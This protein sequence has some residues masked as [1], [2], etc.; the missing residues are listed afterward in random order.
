MPADRIHDFP[1]AL[2]WSVDVGRPDEHLR[3]KA[4]STFANGPRIFRL[5]ER[6]LVI[7]NIIE[8]DEDVNGGHSAAA[9]RRFH[10]Q[11]IRLLRLVV[12][13]LRYEY[14]AHLRIGPKLVRAET[15]QCV[16]QFA[17]GTAVVILCINVTEASAGFRI[18]QDRQFVHRPRELGA[19]IVGI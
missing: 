10:R 4:G 9:V 11:G 15:T 8:F 2:H 17:E 6:R 3:I 14:P 7:V 5:L 16:R 18:F 1:I 12:Q 13:F 19:V